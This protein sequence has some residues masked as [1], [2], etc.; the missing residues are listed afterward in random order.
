MPPKV[1]QRLAKGLVWLGGLITLLIL[2]VVIG[3]VLWNGI[4]ELSWEFLT[5]EPTGG[6]QSTGGI[7]S[8]IIATLW[9]I[10][11]TLILLSPIGLGAA[12]Y[13]AEYAPQNRLTNIIRYGV[14]TLSGVPSIIFGLF[15]YVLFVSIMGFGYSILAGGLTLV[16]LLLPTMIRT[17]EEAIAA[18][19]ADYREAS[20]ALGA[21]R[22]QTIW[23][24]VLPAAM[25]G[26]LT[27]VILCIGR[28][29]EESACLY[30]TMGGAARMPR[31]VM[32][33]ARPLSLHVY[34]LASDIGSVSKAMATAAVLV[35]IVIVINAV[36]N[37]IARRFQSALGM[38]G[39]SVRI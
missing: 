35:I 13:L 17:C 26:L 6:L 4:P 5:T 10:P 25:P 14:E 39:R 32:D 27:A 19:P 28:A 29:I 2:L 21:T 11:I 16:C 36:T 9:L 34:Y 31:S 37:L 38:Q 22:W 23:H 7:S 1:T 12:I 18:V 3:Y 30:V 33:P 20:L 24:V 8:V 15:G